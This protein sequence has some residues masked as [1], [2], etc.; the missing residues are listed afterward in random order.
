MV[1]FLNTISA[2]VNIDFNTQQLPQAW[3]MQGSFA[4]SNATI[5]P[6]CQQNSLI[7]SFFTPSSDFWLQTDTYSY[8][9]NDVNINITYGIKDLYHELG[10]SSP[11]QKPEL[12][13][14][15]QK[16]IQ[17]TGLNMKKFH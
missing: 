7:G 3:T 8:N 17:I 4:I 11:F 12:F 5:H 6:T 15:T 2:Q 14:N 13:W 9:G 10:V 1:L 16:G